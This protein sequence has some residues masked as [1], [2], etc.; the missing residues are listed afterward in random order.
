MT[1]DYYRFCPRCATR[2]IWKQERAGD[3]KV[4]IC[5]KCDFAFYNNP[6]GAT[7][8]VIVKDKKILMIRRMRQPRQ[9]AY[10]FPGGFMSGFETAEQAAIREVR[11]EIGLIFRPKRLLGTYINTQ[12]HWKGRRIPGLAV[13]WL[14]TATGRL[15]LND[16]VA[17][18]EWIPASRK[19]T[20]AFKYQQE[21][22][23]TARK[24]IRTS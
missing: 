13:A 19:I 7:D 18:P 17:H 6:V 16:E 5:P 23:R 24:I 3:T 20:M 21:I 8:S 4:Q 2:L 12:Y 14:G 1:K 9:G 15:K 10:D 11:E 22:L